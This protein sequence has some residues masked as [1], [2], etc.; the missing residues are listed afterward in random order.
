MEA[1]LMPGARAPDRPL[2]PEARAPVL[3]STQKLEKDLDVSDNVSGVNKLHYS[4]KAVP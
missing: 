2:D 3:D 1:G 4:S